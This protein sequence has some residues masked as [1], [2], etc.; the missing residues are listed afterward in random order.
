MPWDSARACLIGVRHEDPSFVCWFAH[1]RIA[2]EYDF[3]SLT[4]CIMCELG[5]S[6]L[7]EAYFFRSFST[8][9]SSC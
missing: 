9:W 4:N 5:V 8:R 6:T 3:L 1:L 2:K 7:H